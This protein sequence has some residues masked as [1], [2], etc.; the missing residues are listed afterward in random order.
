M[1]MWGKENQSGNY[2]VYK[3]GKWYLLEE[4]GIMMINEMIFGFWD[5]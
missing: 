2:W 4:I 5:S 3:G 1:E